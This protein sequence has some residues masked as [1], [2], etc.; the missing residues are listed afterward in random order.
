[1]VSFEG[2]LVAVALASIKAPPLLGSDEGNDDQIALS[3]GTVV[4]GYH[5]VSRVRSVPSTFVASGADDLGL[6]IFGRAPA[7]TYIVPELLALPAVE[8]ASDPSDAKPL[9]LPSPFEAELAS[10]QSTFRLHRRVQRGAH[11]EVWRA[12][13][14][15]D[16]AGTPLV[17]KRL[18]LERG[19]AATL[20]SGMRERHFGRRFRGQSERLARYVDT[21]EEMGSLWLVFRDEGMSLHDLIYSPTD[22]KGQTEAFVTLQPSRA[23]WSLREQ[24]GHCTLRHIVRQA[25]EGVAHMHATGV[26]HRDLKP[27]N[28]IIQATNVGAEGDATS[29]ARGSKEG[30]TAGGSTAA[31]GGEAGGGD[32]GLSIDVA[33][34]S[35]PKPKP[36][37]LPSV[38][39]ADLGSAVDAEVL[40]PKIG[41]YPE[42]G[43][44]VEEETEGYQ[45]PEASL[46]NEPFDGKHPPSYDLWS[47]GVLILELL[48]GTPHV[49]PLTSRTEARL[50][51]KFSDQPPAVLKRL[52]VANALA[53]HCILPPPG[54]AGTQ[55]TTADGATSTTTADGATSTTTADAATSTTTADAA[56]STTTAMAATD[57]PHST[58]S[59]TAPSAAGADSD[60][61]PRAL[62]TSADAARCGKAQF[63]AAVIRADPFAKVLRLPLDDDLI[64]LAWRLLRWEPAERLSATDAL[65]HP[66]LTPRRDANP[67][68]SSWWSSP[69][70]LLRNLIEGPAAA[71]TNEQ[72]ESC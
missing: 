32:G 50:R 16:P 18:T 54:A 64:D 45:P 15:D 31:E 56:A 48:L 22:A 46:G 62:P 67:A 25:M 13:R 58:A 68:S 28:T 44:S 23:W 60:R 43:P 49:L 4:N 19:G 63:V 42:S 20:R 24:P 12:V 55:S 71:A 10:A 21:F 2:L 26:T 29:G 27:A 33:S 35:P 6:E 41:L 66:A 37:P 14:A 52:L 57:A 5:L 38:R 39:L 9:G 7:A 34:D 65:R 59:S 47:M 70:S 11:G 69:R 51:L 72:V 17:L 8:N 61:R 40:Q 30:S 3:A 53:E 1:M 36:M